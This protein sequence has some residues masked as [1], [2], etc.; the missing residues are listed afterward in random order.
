[1][2]FLMKM[3]S[4][5]LSSSFARVSRVITFTAASK[6]TIPDLPYDFNALEPTISADIMRVHYEK[7]HKTYVNNLNIAEEQLAEAMHKN[8]MTKI[9]SLQPAL[10]FNGGGHLNH[11]I[12]WK[13][14]CPN[15]GG[16]PSGPLAEAIKRDF[17]SFEDFKTRMSANTV[18]IQGSGWGWLGFC[19]VSKRL[20]ITTCANQD[21]LEGTTGIVHSFTISLMCDFSPLLIMHLLNHLIIL[22][23]LKLTEYLFAYHFN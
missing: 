19:P 14:L 12:F 13:N 20:R 5:A 7:H 2:E 17:G 23:C 21:P 6:H 9:I 8:D 1:M 15:G 16:E 10:R 3:L 4:R 22:S 18:A 11:S